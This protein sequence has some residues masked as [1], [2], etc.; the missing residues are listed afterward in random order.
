MES[1]RKNLNKI[2]IGVAAAAILIA[3]VLCVDY[4]I[5]R[6]AEKS[7][8]TQTATT[9]AEKEKKD[10]VY[11]SVSSETI[12]EGLA[13]MGILMTQ[14]YYF[15]QVERYTKEKTFLKFITSS[16]EFMYSYD[17]AVMAGVDFEKIR[18]VKDEDQKKITVSMPKSEIIA[19]T[20]D[21]D[22]F[23][24]Y[25]EKESLW[26]PLKLEDY[27]ISLV[28]FENTA[29]EKALASGIL[30]RS[31]EQARKLVSEFIVSLPNTAEYKVE[32]N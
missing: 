3:I 28:E 12:R 19:V 30:E 5:S 9:I 22:T 16:S 26:N 20:I 11:I 24:I 13:N 23:K 27:N 6:K 18:I 2:Y 29:K 10:K 21:K 8:S 4:G 31:D 17:G 32:F 1:I 14:E 15:T 25:S 7:E